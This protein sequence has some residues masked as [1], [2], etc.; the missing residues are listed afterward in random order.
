VLLPLDLILLRCAHKPE[1]EEENFRK[2]HL[3][4]L[5]KGDL[6]FIIFAI[7]QMAT[8]IRAE[9]NIFSTRDF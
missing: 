1:K 7:R 9:M 8:K 4:G 6:V 3:K 2:D 5:D